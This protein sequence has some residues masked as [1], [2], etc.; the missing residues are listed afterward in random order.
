MDR[1]T[2]DESPV[3]VHNCWYVAAWSRDVAG[4]DM[5]TRTVIGQ[6]LLLYRAS[7]GAIVAMDDRCVHRLVPLS[8]GRREGDAVRCMYHG[9]VFDR[10]GACIAVPGQTNVPARARVVAYPVVERNG[11]VWVWMGDPAS[12]DPAL[13][14]V[15]HGFGDAEW[16]MQGDSL[17]YA[18]DYQLINDNL[19]D[20]SHLAY[21]HEQSFQLSSGFAE[22][23]PEVIRLERGIEVHRWIRAG[24][25]TLRQL[26]I[27]EATD[28]LSS[29]R[30]L[31]PGVLLLSN[32]F[33][34]AG[35]AERSGALPPP[36]DLAPIADM[37]SA[38]AITPLLARSC[39]YHFVSGIRAGPGA[40]EF[41]DAHFRMLRTV[42]AED[43]A[44]IEAQQV[45]MDR[46]PSVKM[47]P[48]TRHDRAPVM[49]RTIIA[50]LAARERSETVTMIRQVEV[51]AESMSSS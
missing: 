4:D 29:Y 24:G 17:D 27:T 51:A 1:A 25:A 43:Q 13:V 6:P 21:V 32:R 50:D 42:F 40:A 22:I 30:Y 7:D 35:V 2:S 37:F 3:Y 47:M 9:M 49:M 20:F 31:V 39:R 28:Q 36:D 44:M 5:I 38:Q 23:H 12:A 33:Y 8:R 16:E 14:P 45:A 11:W 26:G 19:T 15:E 10:T 34:P 18:V 41:V 48:F 46:D